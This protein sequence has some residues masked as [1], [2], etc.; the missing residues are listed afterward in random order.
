MPTNI[1]LYLVR[2]W[3]VSGFYFDGADSFSMIDFAAECY[4]KKSHI[5]L[6]L[7]EF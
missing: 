1:E 5:I 2:K 4:H 7:V 3:L 6:D